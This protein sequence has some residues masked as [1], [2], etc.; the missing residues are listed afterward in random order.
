MMKKRPYLLC[1]LL[2]LLLAAPWLSAQATAFQEAFEAGIV[3]EA[4]LSRADEPCSRVEAVQMLDRVHQL[5]YGKPSQYLNDPMVAEEG[6]ET[7]RYFFAQALFFSAME[8]VHPHAPYDNYDAWANYCAE[9]EKQSMWPD[10]QVIGPNTDGSIGEGGVWDHC[11]DLA[12]IENSQNSA[13]MRWFID[14]GHTPAVNYAMI[15]YDRTTGKKVLELDENFCFRPYET[16]TVAQA[17]EA[18][19]RYHRSFEPAAQMIPCEETAAFDPD[20]ITHDL[21]CRQSALPDASCAHLPAQWHGVLMFDMGRVVRQ[22]LDHNPDKQIYEYEIQAV[23][24]AGF[25]FIGLVFDF[26]VLQGPVPQQGCLNETRLKQ[27]DQVIAW[28]LERDIHVDLRMSSP[29]GLTSEHSF[30]E[31]QQWNH[32][33]ANGTDYAPQLASLW[34]ALAQRY[35]AIPNR[36]LS[37][38]LMIEPEISSDDQYAAFFGP[39]IEAIR[40]IS[41]ERCIIADIHCGGLTGTSMAE[42]GVALSYHAYDPREFCALSNDL[43]DDAAYLSTVRWPYQASDQQT[44]DAQKALDSRI[45][46]SVSAN[47]LAVLAR[48]HGVGFMIGEFGI[49]GNGLTRSRY[50]DE[51]L[52]AYYSDMIAH[53]SEKGYGWCSGVWYGSLGIASAYPAVT[54]TAYEQVADHAFYID[55]TMLKWFQE[56]N[57]I[58]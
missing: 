8:A 40:S 49:F 16:M 19:L 12:E 43:Q 35:A 57:G 33:A 41:P 14:F 29:G 1:I 11:P 38:N 5:H 48:S 36:D 26:S 9:N 25:N 18:A 51:T 50:C 39:A 56:W 27:L 52:H 17:A 15:A 53:M 42:M 30:G 10:S 32:D 4:L 20:I 58:N 7:S 2:C 45:E 34:K 47:E 28:C 24:D 44:Y 6:K 13:G 21:L 23:K 37:F 3:N 31:W 46:N 54:S 55:Q 22:A